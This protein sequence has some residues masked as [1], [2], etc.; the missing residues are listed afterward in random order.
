MIKDKNEIID[1][2]VQIFKDEEDYDCDQDGFYLCSRNHETILD[3]LYPNLTN[4]EFI[5]LSEKIHEKIY[6]ERY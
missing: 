3:E 5:E 2:I 1:K 6:K 4:K